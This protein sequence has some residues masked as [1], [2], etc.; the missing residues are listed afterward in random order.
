MSHVRTYPRRALGFVF[1]AHCL[2]AC[3]DGS[4][5]ATPPRLDPP[6]DRWILVAPGTFMMGRDDGDDS[7]VGATEPVHQVTLTRPFWMMKYEVTERE[8]DDVVGIDNNQLTPGD[9][10]DAVQGVNWFEAARYADLLS[11]HE[12]LQP[13]YDT[14]SYGLF[15]AEFYVEPVWPDWQADFTRLTPDLNY[16]RPNNLDCTGYRLPT[17]AEW[18][19]AAGAGGTELYPGAGSDDIAAMDYTDLEFV[20]VGGVYDQAEEFPPNSGP[21][22]VG[23]IWPANKWGFYD[24]ASNVFEWTSGDPRGP[25]PSEPQVYPNPGTG[26]RKCVQRGASFIR[27]WDQRTAYEHFGMWCAGAYWDT[28]FRLVRT[29]TQQDLD[30]YKSVGGE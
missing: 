21:Y 29:A 4:G 28:G 9:P 20:T 16:Q 14:E 22:P 26:D 8:Y 7:I 25:Y 12:G 19:Y 10:D 5:K 3:E 27:G 17:E 18:E 24:F 1:G 2:T 30:T 6:D 23:T 11:V 15:V 13:C